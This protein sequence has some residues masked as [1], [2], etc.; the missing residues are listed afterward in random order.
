M[1][2]RKRGHYWVLQGLPDTE[3]MKPNTSVARL[4]VQRALKANQCKTVWVLVLQI[5][6]LATPQGSLMVASSPVD[7]PWIYNGH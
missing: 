2:T 3:G 4:C 1:D 6:K 5:N 7:G